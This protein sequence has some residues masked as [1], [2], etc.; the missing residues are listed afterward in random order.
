MS[1]LAHYFEAAGIPT[2]LSALVRE[3]AVAIKPPRALSVPF[4]LGRPLGAPEHA[5]FQTRVIAAAL[6]LLERP[7]GPILEDYPEDAPADSNHR[8]REVHF[9][10]GA[11]RVRNVLRAK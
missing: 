11:G 6:E 5:A 8:V 10:F 7:S 4:E 2:T 9:P 1:A 3:H